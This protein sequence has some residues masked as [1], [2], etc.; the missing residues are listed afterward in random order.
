MT[1][2]SRRLSR[3]VTL[4]PLAI[5]SAAWT[6]NVAGVS[7]A[8]VAAS[9]STPVTPA[10]PPDVTVP[11]ASYAAP[12]SVSKPPATTVVPVAA[13][14]NIADVISGASSTA[15][16]GAA[17]AAY[18]RAATVIDEADRSCHLDWSV[19]A[20]IGRVESD[21]GRVDGNRLT[22]AGIATP[23]VFGP[24]LTG[25]GGTARIADTDGGRY[26]G[27]A[28]F[29]RAVGPM[30]FIPSTWSLVGVDADGDG[31]RDPQ[32]INDAALATAVYLCSGSGDLATRAGQRAAVF[33]YNHRWSYVAT[34][35]AIAAAYRAGDFS[36]ETAISTL[37][38]AAP[39]PPGDIASPGS[40]PHHR[41]HGHRHG[42]HHVTTLGTHAGVGGLPVHGD[43]S[44]ATSTEPAAASTTAPGTTPSTTPSATDTPATDE[45]LTEL[46]S[47]QIGQTYP[48]ATADAADQATQLCREE[49]TGLSASA[50]SNAVADVVGQLEDRVA[51]LDGP[52][53]DEPSPS[54]DPSP[55]D[56]ASPT[57]TA[58][59]ASPTGG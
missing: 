29:D 36:P 3:A 48:D 1:G 43:P 47:Q 4:A 53:S 28:R 46:C 25:R 45:E 38:L 22:P 40:L 26:D 23:G 44:D 11:D 39:T 52:T 18:Q 20:A 2:R 7:P 5:L 15:I 51:G 55:T 54:S 31:K 56:A 10:P 37:R 13:T 17:L 6:A 14:K 50:A 59:D 8:T 9:P 21:D 35:L 24:A 32:D 16:P 27:D 57:P 41:H 58:P 30:Q 33:R 42:Q 34:V 49:L 12:V 19:I